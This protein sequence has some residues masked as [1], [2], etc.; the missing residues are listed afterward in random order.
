MI[1]GRPDPDERFLR[2][3]PNFGVAIAA[4]SVEARAPQ[5]GSLFPWIHFRVDVVGVILAGLGIVAAVPPAT[6]PM[7]HW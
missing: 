3:E 4:I 2:A 6:E 1:P 5:E 7:K